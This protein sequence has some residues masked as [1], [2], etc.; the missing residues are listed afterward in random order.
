MAESQGLLINDTGAV[1]AGEALS[2]LPASYG[3]V[4]I[5]ISL[6]PDDVSDPIPVSSGQVVVQVEG[7]VPDSPYPLDEVREKVNDDLLGDLAIRRVK[8]ALESIRDKGEG[9]T[10]LARR[11]D[12]EVKTREDLARGASLPGISR[13]ETI[14][15]QL[16][17]LP[18]RSL[19]EPVTT[20]SGIVVLSVRERV[21]HLDKFASRRVA[22]FDTLLQ[23]RRDRLVR[24]FVKRL[25]ENGRVEINN[26]LVQAVD[27]N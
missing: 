5:M 17:S 3:I 25:R 27:R 16:R 4:S 12:T 2:T 24:G 15:R 26:P 14:N 13:D 22:T 1:H 6:D 23:Q 8:Q 11:L 9:I 18:P 10:E 21:D 7:V 19:G 20:A